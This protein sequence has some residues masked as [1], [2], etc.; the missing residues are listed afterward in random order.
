MTA[1]QQHN[2]RVLTDHLR[3]LSN[4]QDKAADQILGANRAVG[5]TA[6]RVSDSHGLVCS[7]TSIALSTADTVRKEAGST[8]E[9]VSRELSEKLTTA[10]SNYEN[11]DY[12]AGRKIDQTANM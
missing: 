5:D 3:D 8:M 11:T 9:K 4:S 1:D 6:R 10:A 12:L 2:L 7:I